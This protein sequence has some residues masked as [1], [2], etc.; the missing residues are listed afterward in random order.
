[1]TETKSAMTVD[2]E[3]E[4]KERE[5]AALRANKLAKERFKAVSDK[6]TVGELREVL[7]GVSPLSIIILWS[8]GGL[9]VRSHDSMGWQRGAPTLFTGNVTAN[10]VKADG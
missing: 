5:L 2:Q 1:M 9:T 7:R 8:D 3:I 6:T 4:L 10:E